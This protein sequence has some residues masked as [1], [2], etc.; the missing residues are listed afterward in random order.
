[1]TRDR[2]RAWV[3]GYLLWVIAFTVIEGTGR[4]VCRMPM[5]KWIDAAADPR[6]STARVWFRD[7]ARDCLHR[8]R[9]YSYSIAGL[10]T[11]GLFGPV[12]VAWRLRSR[13]LRTCAVVFA[14]SLVITLGT[15]FAIRWA[16]DY[17]G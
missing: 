11:L 12:G 3:I 6:D 4:Q 10:F 2:W 15:M 16:Y 8:T 13:A 14:A 7:Q 17:L 5:K 9:W 1:M